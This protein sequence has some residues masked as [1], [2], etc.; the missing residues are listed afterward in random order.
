VGTGYDKRMVVAVEL[1]ENV[2]GLGL[3]KTVSKNTG[4]DGKQKGISI[5]FV[6]QHAV[7]AAL[8]AKTLDAED[9][10][11]GRSIV[12]VDFAADDAKYVT[13]QFDAEMDRQLVSKYLIDARPIRA[14]HAQPQ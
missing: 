12:E 11:I 5:Y 6:S 9:Q 4:I 2:T 7:T 13:F 8:V 3:S 14:N 1:T 10:E